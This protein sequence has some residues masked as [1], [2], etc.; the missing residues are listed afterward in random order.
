MSLHQLKHIS[1]PINIRGLHRIMGTSKRIF[2][3]NII[4][5]IAMVTALPLTAV[6]AS[7]ISDRLY[8]KVKETK[9]TEDEM[10]ELQKNL[11]DYGFTGEDIDELHALNVNAMGKTYGPDVLGADLI[12]VI[13]DEEEIGY[14][15]REELEGDAPGSIAEAM[16]EQLEGGE[17]R[18]PIYKSDGMT[19]IGTFSL[20]NGE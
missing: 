12:E 7:H 20:L 2:I 5:V 15:Y 6:A 3:F 1:K 13:S 19:V 11:Q 17:K 16:Q 10:L 14:I 9:Y 8:E 4:I 18:I